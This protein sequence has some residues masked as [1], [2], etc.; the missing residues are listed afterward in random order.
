M[1]KPD[2]R[3]PGNR[4]SN[5]WQRSEHSPATYLYSYVRSGV[6]IQNTREV[7]KLE[8]ET[9]ARRTLQAGGSSSK[10]TDGIE[11]KK[12]DAILKIPYIAHIRVT[13]FYL[14]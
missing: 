10:E 11:L 13:S 7:L 8:G 4:S 3:L 14:A 1:A 2:S 5:R 6:D 9:R 12:R